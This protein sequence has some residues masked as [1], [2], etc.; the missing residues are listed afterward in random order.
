MIYLG[1]RYEDA[2]IQYVLDKRLGSTRATVFRASVEP[3]EGGQ[4]WWWRQ[5]DRID[6]LA[7]QYYDSPN[8]WWRIMD[9]NP[10]L[11]DPLNI[12]VGTKI[13]IP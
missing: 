4:Y 9:A 10:E 13:R 11:L 1:S 8:Q 6:T 2:D 3:E 12:S 5:E 7:A